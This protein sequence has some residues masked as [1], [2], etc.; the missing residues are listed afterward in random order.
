MVARRGAPRKPPRNWRLRGR[1]GCGRLP[2][3]QT[4]TFIVAAKSVATVFA[5][6]AAFA[7]GAFPADDVKPETMRV[8][9]VREAAPLSPTEIRVVLGAA[10]TPAAGDTEAWRILAE[11]DPAYAYTSFV[12]PVSVRKIAEKDEFALP[13][14]DESPECA[15]YKALDAIAY[16][17]KL[18]TPMRDGARYWAVAHGRMRHSVPVTGGRSE[19]FFEFHASGPFAKAELPPPDDAVR[20]TAG[21]R[22]LWSVGGG[23]VRLDCGAGLVP[24][25]CDDPQSYAVTLNGEPVTP[26]SLG[27]RSVI[28]VYKPVGWPYKALMRHDVF[29]DLGAPLKAGDKVRV[30]VAATAMAA[31]ATAEAELLFDE[32][33]SVSDVIKA[34]QVGYLPDAAKDA[35]IGRWLGSAGALDFPEAPRFEVR[36]AVTHAVAFEGVA[37][38]VH[39][40]GEQDARAGDL[41]GENVWALD[42]TPLAAEGTYY[43]AVPGVGRSFAFRIAADAYA[44]AFAVAA[45]GLVAQRC[46]IE[47]KKPW[48]PWNRIAC[49]VKGLVPTTA[50]RF[51]APP[52]VDLPSMA[53]PGAAPI[54][55]RGGH[56]DAGDYNPRSHLDVARALLDAFDAAP[57]KFK[58]GQMPVPPDEHANGIPDIVDEALWELR[59]WTGL[60]DEDGG[61]R[62]GTES[63]GDPNFFQTVELDDKGDYAFAKE[64]PAS[65]RFAG[66]AA[67]CSRILHSCGAGAGWAKELLD[68]AVAAW[69]WAEAHPSPLASNPKKRASLWT[70]P[71]AYAAAHLFATT[72]EE[73]FH[74]AFLETTPWKKDPKAPLVRDGTYDHRASAYAYVRCVPEDK[75]DP[76]IRAAAKKAIIREADRLIQTA[77]A[78][79]YPF[80]RHPWAPMSWGTAAYPIHLAPVVY[81]WAVT[82][83]PKYRDWIVRTCDNTLG[84]NPMST[85]WM[86][87][88]GSRRI[89]APLHNSRYAP[90]GPVAGLQ[91]QGPSQRGEGYRY[92]ETA[93]PKHRSD[94]ASLY[95]FVDVHFAIAMDEGTVGSQATTLAAFGLLLPD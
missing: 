65:Y 89:H 42:F 86:T 5:L 51:A 23:F 48:F 64:S 9:G 93:Y 13:P 85:C 57:A 91:C 77:E 32:R 88:I 83:D 55:A 62:G 17:L 35:R 78:T 63:G 50:F 70:T 20:A 56:H 3:M 87:G 33:T 68:R 12:R 38:S 6:L 18:P 84:C 44:P 67:Q 54:P 26:R 39:R 8:W 4:S 81:A 74:Q 72:G 27:R 40:A 52:M 22:G 30:S 58:D 1:R 59:L 28:D 47:L 76:D 36:D 46:G 90:D 11:G 24:P 92:K 37:R 21:V 45:N 95:A 31:G 71:R 69:D 19:A 53:V 2:R 16:R 79:A 94:T 15:K 66:T 25:A 34:N 60:Q 43:L 82:G 75:A 10:A 49:H 14:G 61:V 7:A 41:S 73:R 80:I 29:L